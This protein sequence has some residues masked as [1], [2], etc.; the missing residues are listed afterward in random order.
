MVYFGTIS[1]S[2]YLWQQVVT[3]PLKF[4]FARLA[5][6]LGQGVAVLCFG[7]CAF[8]GITVI[9]HLS[10]KL[11]EVR[12]ARALKRAFNREER[13]VEQSPMLSS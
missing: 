8:A 3:F 5:P 10:Y 6:R 13:S 9:S 7:L 11:L 1:Y 4:V 2:F 12:A